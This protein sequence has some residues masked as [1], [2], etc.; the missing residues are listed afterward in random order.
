MLGRTVEVEAIV[1]AM[2]VQ[3]QPILMSDDNRLPSGCTCHASR[4]YALAP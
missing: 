3:L 2:V 4:S 1:C